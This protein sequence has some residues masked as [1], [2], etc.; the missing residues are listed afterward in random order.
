[1]RHIQVFAKGKNESTTM[2]SI[3]QEI[4]L[5]FSH[6]QSKFLSVALGMRTLNLR[7]AHNTR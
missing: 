3:Q 2:Q 5:L 7:S 1:M 4:A 6:Y